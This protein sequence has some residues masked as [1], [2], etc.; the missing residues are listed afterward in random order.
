MTDARKYLA[1]LAA[2][3]D[4]AAVLLLPKRKK[5]AGYGIR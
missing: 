1:K 3:E 4:W 2:D 5:G